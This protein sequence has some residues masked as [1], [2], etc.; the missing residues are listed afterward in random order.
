M[1]TKRGIVNI[2]WRADRP[3]N[4]LPLLPPEPDEVKTRSALKACIPARAAKAELRQADGQTRKRRGTTCRI[5]GIPAEDKARAVDL[6]DPSIG[7]EHSRARSEHLDSSSEHLA[8][9]SGHSSTDDPTRDPELLRL[10]EPVRS[11]RKTTPD[12]V[13][14]TIL[15]LCSDRFLTLNQLAEL[16]DR[17]A[18]GIRQRFVKPM[19]D[20]EKVL[21]RRFPRQPNHEQQAYRARKQ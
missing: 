10:A 17:S 14:S 19:V 11:T 13:R 9:S 1:S 5:A 2:T 12:T 8:A 15:S 16:L 7:S 21:E 20:E 6:S 4:E 3:F 18:D